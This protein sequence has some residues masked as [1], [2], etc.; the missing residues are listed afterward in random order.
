MDNMT[1]EQ[2][3]QLLTA[4]QKDR[5]ARC[6]WEELKLPQ[7][8][9]EVEKAFAFG[10]Y[11]F[12]QYEDKGALRSY[13]MSEAG[14]AEPEQPAP[15]PAPQPKPE[16]KPE[17]VPAP[18]LPRTRPDACVE[19]PGLLENKHT[20]PVGISYTEAVPKR[21]VPA[22]QP[23]KAEPAAGENKGGRPMYPYIKNIPHEQTQDLAALVS[24]QPGQIVSRTLAQNPAVSLTLFAFDEGEEISTH[25]SEGDAMVQ[26]LEGEG[27]FTV[28]G[29][30][31]TVSAGQVLVMPAGKPHAVY[32]PRSFKMLLTVVFPRKD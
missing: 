21:T 18:E 25:S 15:A 23:P 4:A 12:V 2:A 16:P 24:V 9:N 1:F 10:L 28:D 20:E 14:S 3:E 11:T 8:L 5:I 27:L 22:A 13:F 7:G 30:E 26:V 29:T 6:L 17:P 32:A 31:H 19:N